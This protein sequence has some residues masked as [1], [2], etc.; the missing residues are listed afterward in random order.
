[1]TFTT[2]LFEVKDSAAHITLNRPERYN[3]L[4]ETMIAEL[5]QAVKACARDAGVRAVLLTGTGKGFC[6]GADLLEL[7]ENPDVSVGDHLRHGL[8][9][10]INDMRLLEKPIVGAINGAAAGAG[11]SLALAC[12][13]RVASDK[14]SFVFGAFVNIGLIP[15]AGATYLLAELV[16]AA[17][18]LEMAVLMDA[19]NRLSAEQALHWGVVNRVVA[20]ETLLSEANALTARLAQMATRAVGMSK[21]AIYS[22]RTASLTEALE[23]EAQTQDRMAQT[24]DHREGVAAFIEKRTP[25]F[26]GQ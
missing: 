14:A 11:G 20:H 22:A 9:L 19:Q 4:N 6:S 7:A 8:N 3:A 16:G 21:R 5:R 24:H 25:V 2:L 26:K 12:D 1:M 10:L 23:Y 13:F 18:A 17:R 15:D